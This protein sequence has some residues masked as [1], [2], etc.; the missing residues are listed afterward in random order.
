MRAAGP[1]PKCDDLS[2]ITK[3]SAQVL[4]SASEEFSKNA[5]DRSQFS[6]T[7]ANTLN[8]AYKKRSCVPI[9]TLVNDISRAVA[10]VNPN[11]RPR[12]GNITNLVDEGGTFFFIAK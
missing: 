6:M 9:E 10:S 7:F 11:Q 1:E 3:K 5:S 12:F 2:K 8:G 4:T